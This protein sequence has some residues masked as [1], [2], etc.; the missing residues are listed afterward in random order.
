MT[1]ITSQ[2]HKSLIKYTHTLTFVDVSN[3]SGSTVEYGLNICVLNITNINYLY[4]V[5]KRNVQTS[6]TVSAILIS[7]K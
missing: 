6:V 4:F 7:S 5:R 2:S 1:P 3:F